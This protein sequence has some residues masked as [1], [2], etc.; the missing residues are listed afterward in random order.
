[1]KRVSKRGDSKRGWDGT[2][3]FH[4]LIH[5]DLETYQKVE[6]LSFLSSFFEFISIKTNRHLFNLTEIRKIGNKRR[7]ITQ[8]NRKSVD[9]DSVV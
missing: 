8:F 9:V 2:N 7:W 5:P 1:M 4:N 6:A 3:P